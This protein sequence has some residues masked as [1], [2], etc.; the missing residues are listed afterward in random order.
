MVV[1]DPT[2]EELRRF[3]V[4]MLCALGVVGGLLWWLAPLGGLGRSAAIVVWVVGACVAVLS[5]AA[6]G[7][8]RPLHRGWMTVA[9]WLSAVMM[10]VLLTVL[11]IA[12]LPFFTFIRLGDPLR[13]RAEHESYWEPH[14]RD[15]PSL[16][17]VLRPF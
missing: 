5:W 17:R 10:A 1:R 11:F 3:G 9:A 16:D 4:T 12:L 2:R 7:L 15:A 13:K 14:A 6:P 8:G